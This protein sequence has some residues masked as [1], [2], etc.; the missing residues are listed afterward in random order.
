MVSKYPIGTYHIE[1]TRLHGQSHPRYAE[2]PVQRRFLLDILATQRYCCVVAI[3]TFEPGG[4]LPPGV[5]WADWQEF[6][7]RFGLS[8][9][10]RR[11]LL[12][13]HQALKL[14]QA[15]GCVT[16]Y[17]DGS[18]VT[19]KDFP[20]DFDGC[21]DVRGVDPNK[22]DP[23]F[24]DLSNK[25]AAQKARFLGEFFPA[26]VPNGISGRTFLEFFQI[27]KNT[28]IQKGIVAIDLRRL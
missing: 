12:G 27:D 5:Y 17:I 8:P 15:A 13:L 1:T 14:L 23:V 19:Q 21:W 10:R 26:Q 6:A 25:R 18:F 7:A 24:L 2:L 16:A 20:G 3:P 4:N 9:Y 28:G 11:I 22:L